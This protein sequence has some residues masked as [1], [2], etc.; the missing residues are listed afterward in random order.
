MPE[1]AEVTQSGLA[2]RGGAR[3]PRL[4]SLLPARAGGQAGRRARRRATP[5]FQGRTRSHSFTSPQ[6]GG[7]GGARL[8]NGFLVL[9]KVGRVAVRWSRPLE[10]TPKTVTISREADGWYAVLSCA[11]VPAQPLTPTGRETGIDVGLQ[12]FL[13]TADGDVVENPRHY[14]RGEKQLAKAQRRVRRR[15]KGSQRRRKA[16]RPPAAGAPDGAAPACRLPPADRAC[17]AASVRHASLSKM[18]GSPTWCGTVPWPSPSRTRA[19]RSSVPSSRPRQHAPGVGSS[20]CRPPIPARTAAAVGNA[21][22]KR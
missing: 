20:P 9:A 6:V 10:G 19:G 18:C 15:K 11:E 8:E 13:I 7:H 17:S 12:V 2:G 3:R 22:P 4:P 1:Y 5:R 21:C 16:V 14:R